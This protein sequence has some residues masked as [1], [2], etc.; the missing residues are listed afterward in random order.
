M[1]I[2]PPQAE[3][4][5]Y[6]ERMFARIAPSYDRV[7]RIMT[8][9]LDQPWRQYVVSAVAPPVNGC[10][11][12]IGT[13][14]GDF[15]PLLAAWM[16]DG[17]AVGVDFCVPMMHA[18]WPKLQMYSNVGRTA[19]IRPGVTAFAGGDALQLPFPDNTFDTITT[20]FAMRN[21]TNIGAAF[22]EMWRVARPGACMA[23]LEVARPQ[24]PLL[25]LG[26]QFYFE[27]IVPWIGL[28]LSGDRS[29]YMYLPQSARAFPTPPVL[30]QM[31]RDA[32]WE[33]VTYKLL[34]MG[35]VA[36]HVG[37]KL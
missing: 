33:Y 4:A 27:Q 18:G 24:N 9:G 1:S 29:A 3:K 34:G 11:L 21:V 13:G 8:F 26:H 16:P 28:L 20:G 22:H 10:A 6:V 7:N 36:V 2:L 5:T 37:A 15:L 14:T 19:S 32:G 30:A 23:C 31:M 17:I 35:S 12:D 25:R